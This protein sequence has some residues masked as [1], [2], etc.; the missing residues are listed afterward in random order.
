MAG[1]VYNNGEKAFIEGLLAGQ[2]GNLGGSVQI[3]PT[4][5]SNWGF[6]LGT[7]V[8]GVG[9]TKADT[10]T[11]IAELG[12]TTPNGY[13][14]TSIARNLTGWPAPSLSGGSYE[15][16][17]AQQTISFTGAPNPNGATMW[18]IAGD[19]TISHDNAIFGADLSATRTFGNGDQE[20]VTPT[21][22]QT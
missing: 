9:S 2:T 19:T 15:S 1:I 12:T 17:I 7:R 20:L 21:Y 13:G 14:R 10:I 4:A 18:F 5:G 8:G 6:G 22:Q 16:T 11:Q 3:I